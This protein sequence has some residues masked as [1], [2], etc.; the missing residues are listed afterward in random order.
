M[1]FHT[2][3][4]REGRL[5]KMVNVLIRREH[6][7]VSVL[8]DTVGRSVRLTSMNAF[9][10]LAKIMVYV[11]VAWTLTLACVMLDTLA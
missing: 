1:N 3:Y 6:T 9:Q 5:A 10:I 4:A 7:T 2:A 11:S 8:L